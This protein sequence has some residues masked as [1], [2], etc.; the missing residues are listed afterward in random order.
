MNNTG[1]KALRVTQLDA[2][3]LTNQAFRIIKREIK[4]SL[5]NKPFTRLLHYE[6][7]IDVLLQFIIWKYSLQKSDSTVGQLYFKMKYISPNGI[8]ERQ[9]LIYFFLNSTRYWIV[10]RQFDILHVFEKLF[11]NPHITLFVSK[12]GTLF[13]LAE[14][15]NYVL[16]IKNGEYLNL[17]DR[18]FNWKT[19]RLDKPSPRY[20]D[21]TYMRKELLW[22]KITETV[23]CVLPFINFPKLYNF[24][25][26]IIKYLGFV[27]SL[28]DNLEL[29]CNICGEKPTNP[30]VS[31]CDHLFCWYC[32]KG[33][34]LADKSYRCPT[35]GKNI[36]SIEQFV[37]E[38]KK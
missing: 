14:F 32:I 15:V 37:F 3:Y 1:Y 28:T 26:L 18:F 38:P 6:Q 34:I 19:I 22:S 7:E 30:Q 12:L 21:Y 5:L 11:K 20:I 31:N 8:S 33:N 13:Q 2:D 25:M 16:F 24:F 9:K 29:N 4:G 23:F 35:C 10:N 17:F 36:L 27:N